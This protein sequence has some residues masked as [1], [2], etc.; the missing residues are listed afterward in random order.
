MRE[1]KFRAWDKITHR[2]LGSLEI[3]CFPLLDLQG[4]NRY[5]FMQFTGLLDKNGKEIYEG[6][7]ISFDKE[8]KYKRRW[9][10][11]WKNGV[12][13]SLVDGIGYRI[14][15]SDNFPKCSECGI[16]I[17]NIYEDPELLN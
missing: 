8:P 10:I 15:E 7:I 17:G 12:G 14:L 5:I 11:R 16:V 4:D 3:R 1:I 9:E 2:I 13:F 6:D